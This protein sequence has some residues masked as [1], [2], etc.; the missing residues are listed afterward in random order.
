MALVSVCRATLAAVFGGACVLDAFDGRWTHLATERD[1]ACAEEEV[2]PSGGH[3]RGET[4]RV[5]TDDGT[6]R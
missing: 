5:Q 2:S 3:R 6:V 4:A 1:P